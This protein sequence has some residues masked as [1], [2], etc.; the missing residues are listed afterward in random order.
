MYPELPN[1]EL[2]ARRARPGWDAW[3]DEIARRAAAE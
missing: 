1:I 2:F 3:G